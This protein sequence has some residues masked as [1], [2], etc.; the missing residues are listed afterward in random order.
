MLKNDGGKT[1]HSG[2]KVSNKAQVIFEACWRKLEEKYKE[3]HTC[4][5]EPGTLTP[6]LSAY[7][8]FLQGIL[9]DTV[10]L[11]PLIVIVRVSVHGT[12]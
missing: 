3:V 1:F 7:P 6:V 8:L 2:D 9:H 11:C 4:I 5:A 12:G 10:S